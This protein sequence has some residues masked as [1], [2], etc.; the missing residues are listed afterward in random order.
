[1]ITGR[2][3]IVDD[4][5]EMAQAL[6]AGLVAEGHEVV[7]CETGDSA[8]EA[9][10]TR[11]LDVVLTDLRMRGTSGIELCRRI[12]TNRTDLPVMVMTA[13]GNL[14]TA[15]AAMRAGAFDMLTKPFEMEE[16]C[17]AVGR[18]LQH[19]ALRDEVKR[20]REEIA[21]THGEGELR[22][23]SPPM[24]ALRQLVERVAKSDAT[25]LITGESGSGK[26][27]VAR[28]IHARSARSAGPM[29]TIN[30]AAMPEPLLESELFGH[31][32]GVESFSRRRAARSSSTNSA[33]YRSG[34]RPSSFARSKLAASGR[35][36]ATPRSP[37]MSGCSPPPIV[38][39]RLP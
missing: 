15:V 25:T 23:S 31:V 19:R 7:V 11:E 13:F 2:I 26:E 9:L 12:V 37:S 18:A 22:G 35:W 8:L 21:T 20:L 32:R 16:L 17:F 28:A 39:S 27:V 1:M 6:A 24:V 3:L 34:F 36:A 5:P 38:I 10:A 29:V 14:D 33:S 4:E 30:C